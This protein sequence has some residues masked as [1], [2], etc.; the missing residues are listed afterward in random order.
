MVDGILEFL[1]EAR[2]YHLGLFAAPE[3]IEKLSR[4]HSATE[5]HLGA[6][7][8]GTVKARLN[9]VSTQRDPPAYVSLQMPP[10]TQILR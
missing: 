6:I 1:P 5:I 8:I 4:A 3:G 9:V 2:V 10:E 7:D